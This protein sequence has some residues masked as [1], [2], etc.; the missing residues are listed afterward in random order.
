MHATRFHFAPIVLTILMTSNAINGQ[1]IPRPRSGSD[2][3][4]GPRC[5]SYILDYYHKDQIQLVDLVREMQWPDIEKGAT[6]K[7]IET[8]LN[9]RDVYTKAVKIDPSSRLQWPFPV[10][11]HLEEP[12]EMGHYVVWLPTSTADQEIIWAGLT[13]LLQGSA[14]AISEKRSGAVILTS[15]KPISDISHAARHRN[16]TIVTVIKGAL[17]L[18]VVSISTSLVFLTIHRYLRTRKQVGIIA[19]VNLRQD[20]DHNGLDT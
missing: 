20:G 15:P 10:I 11:V 19:K 14:A 7:S 4:C 5:V 8:S 9:S 12:P 16:D 2:M 13:G 1:I 17:A 6:I 18:V 3:I